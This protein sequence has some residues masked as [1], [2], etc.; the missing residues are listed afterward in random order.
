MRLS[1]FGGIAQGDTASHL[2]ACNKK[3]KTGQQ[4]FSG[5]STPKNSI[6]G[7]FSRYYQTEFIELKKV[8]I[9]PSAH[10]SSRPEG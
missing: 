4:S 8:G 6:K 1:L 3:T 9:L 2:H 7:S 10:E 5:S